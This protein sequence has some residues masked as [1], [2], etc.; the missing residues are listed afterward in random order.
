MRTHLKILSS[1][2]SAAMIMSSLSVAALADPL[3]ELDVPQVTEA[4]QDDAAQDSGS[5]FDFENPHDVKTPREVEKTFDWDLT[6]D[7][8]ITE[9]VDLTQTAGLI[10]DGDQAQVAEEGQTSDFYWILYDDGLLEIYTTGYYVRLGTINA[11][12]AEKVGHVNEDTQRVLNAAT[13]VVITLY[14]EINDNDDYITDYDVDAKADIY[15]SIYGADCNAS[16][17]TVIGDEKTYFNSLSISDFPN[18]DSDKT[19]IPQ[20]QSCK[21]VELTNLGVTSLDFINGIPCDRLFVRD[22]NKLQSINVPATAC[23]TTV[24]DCEEINNITF[25]DS[26]PVISE[27]NKSR[28]VYVNLRYLPN[29]SKL[30][31]PGIDDEQLSASFNVTNCGIKEIEIPDYSKHVDIYLSGNTELEKATLL[32]TQTYNSMFNNC[33]SLSEVNLPDG[34]TT[35]EYA[36]FKGCSSLKSI[37]LPDSVNR[38]CARAFSESG[39]A[40]VNIPAGVTTLEYATFKNCKSLKTAYLPE[41]LKIIDIQAFEGCTALTDVYYAGTEEQWNKITVVFDPEEFAS[42]T[43]KDVFGNATIHFKVTNEWVQEGDDWYYF[44]G[45]G[46]KVT[47]WLK[48]DGIWY[49]FEGS[50]A[51]K[52]GWLKSGGNWYYMTQSGAMA[53]GW[54]QSGGNWYYFDNTGAMYTGWLDYGGKRYYLDQDGKMVTGTV[55]IDGRTYMFDP[56]GALI[57]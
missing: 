33:T 44:D 23:R 1:V 54:K 48:I 39:L 10:Q 20:S 52:T 57:R 56:T 50:G 27:S 4:T 36:M 21:T 25:D 8:E 17:L 9:S 22:C 35:I 29:L 18:L 38:I 15:F 6:Q 24:R 47:G 45:D 46:N 26:W 30:S 3:E 13:S 34:V 5:A 16:S 40:S 2:L 11:T 32:G 12:G 28:D 7:L 14:R 53:T 43:L 51:M 31:L 41:E 42:G 19:V 37:E 49:Y 55:R